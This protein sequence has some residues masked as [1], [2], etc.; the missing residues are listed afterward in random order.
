MKNEP[1]YQVFIQRVW[2]MKV[3]PRFKVFAW[4]VYYKKIL[5]AE[6]LA[7]RGWNM[8]SMCVLCRQNDESIKH[9]FMSVFL[10]NHVL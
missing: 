10:I 1:R 9:V 6:N 5:T 8:P 4:L 2:K 3:P 7:K